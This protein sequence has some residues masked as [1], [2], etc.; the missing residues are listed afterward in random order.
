M[1]DFAE[2]VGKATIETEDNAAVTT[3]LACVYLR[4]GAP[5]LIQLRW[6]AGRDSQVRDVT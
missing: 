6:C 3:H 4:T 2:P 1:P 5:E